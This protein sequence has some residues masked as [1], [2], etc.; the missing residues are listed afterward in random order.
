[1]ET[2]RKEEIESEHSSEEEDE[3]GDQRQLQGKT[4][5]KRGIEV[6]CPILAFEE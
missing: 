5:T 6:W 3:I 4:K 2:G 1:M